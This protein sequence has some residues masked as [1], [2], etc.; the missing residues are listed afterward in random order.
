MPFLNRVQKFTLYFFFFSINFEM[1]RPIVDNETFSASKVTAILYFFMIIPQYKE[2]FRTDNIKRFL[3]PVFI[4]GGL[5][6]LMSI[7][8]INEVTSDFV[9]T[10]LL[11]NI[12]FFWIVVNHERKEYLV[13][14][15]AMLFFA[16]GTVA[17]ALFYIL[18]IGVKYEAGR[19]SM[20]GDDQNYIAFRTS[21]GIII[22]VLAALQ[23]RLKM[24][25]YR[26]LLLLPIPLMLKLM[27]ET[28]SRGAFLTFAV[29]FLVGIFLFKTKDLWRKVVAIILGLA[30][31]I[32]AGFQLLQS[33]TMRNRLENSAETED[34]GGRTAIWN[35]IIPIIKENLVFGTGKTG[36]IYK[37]TIIYGE[38]VSPH[39]V[40]LE[41]LCYTGFVGLIIYFIFLYQI[42]I[43]SYAIYKQTALLLPILLL[44][45]LLGMILSIQ[46]LTK[47]FGWIIF[48]Y[49]V[50]TVALKNDKL[51]SKKTV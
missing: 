5:Q 24:N 31:F 7:L 20:F 35:A 9:D 47:K 43:N 25:W 50:S 44:V 37:S 11:L 3:I 46:L 48:S 18:G 2:F 13:I 33:E 1:L 10:A 51:Y 30:F 12:I 40:I 39:N 8:N 49:I 34:T 41:I 38:E 19:L 17:L 36:Y 26:Y 23:N 21:V 42:G 15:K 16:L 29:T 27:S 28:G 6:T 14:E 22:L 32:I 4:F 45:P